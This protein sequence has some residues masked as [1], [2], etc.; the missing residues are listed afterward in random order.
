MPRKLTRSLKE[1][2]PAKTALY[3]RNLEEVAQSQLQ[4]KE[5]T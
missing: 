2:N 1:D 5:P 3:V 4:I